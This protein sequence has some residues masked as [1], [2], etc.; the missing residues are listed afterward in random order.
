MQAQLD[1][2]TAKAAQLH[3]DETKQ[4]YAALHQADAPIEMLWIMIDRMEEFFSPDVIES[5]ID[6]LD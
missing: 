1:A 5:F 3:G 6:S 2:F 4:A